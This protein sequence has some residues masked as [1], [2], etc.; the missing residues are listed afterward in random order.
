MATIQTQFVNLNDLMSIYAPFFTKQ[1][2]EQ[3]AA[4][5]LLL[6]SAGLQETVDSTSPD[7]TIR[8]DYDNYMSSLNK[9]YDSMSKGINFNNASLSTE[10]YRNYGRLKTKVDKAQKEVDEGYKT[11]DSIRS[12]N[13]TAIF[14]KTNLETDMDAYANGKKAE[15]GFVLGETIVENARKDAAALGAALF[16]DPVFKE[17][18]ESKGYLV[19]A[20]QYKGYSPKIL[21][22]VVRQIMETGTCDARLCSDET[23]GKIKTIIDVQRQRAQYKSADK[24]AREVIDGNIL[25]GLYLGLQ[26]AQVQYISSGLEQQQQHEIQQQQVD[27]ARSKAGGGH[28]GGSSKK[29]GNSSTKKGNGKPAATTTQTTPS[30]SESPSQTAADKDIKGKSEQ[31]PQIVEQKSR[32]K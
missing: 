6:N 10:I 12:A 17:I 22:E 18:N 31:K 13:P 1:A 5:E 2:E 20:T 3:K 23:A 30:K 25:S 24:E 14:L 21:D 8:K 15:N 27:I 4:R 19:N 9:W 7:S 16:G 26:N 32:R 29:S 28:S 11:R